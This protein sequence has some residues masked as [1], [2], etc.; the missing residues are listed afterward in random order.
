MKSTLSTCLLSV[1]H[2][3]QYLHCFLQRYVWRLEPK[4][5]HSKPDIVHSCCGH[6]PSPLPSRPSKMILADMLRRP[7]TLWPKSIISHTFAGNF[8]EFMGTHAGTSG[9]SGSKSPSSC[10]HSKS[11][12]VCLP[13]EIRCMILFLS[14][15]HPCMT[16]TACM[17]WTRLM[18]LIF[19]RNN[20]PQME[21]M[22]QVC[23]EMMQ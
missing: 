16:P 1:L 3:I 20:F 12:P 5:G 6:T 10:R 9:L 17:Q 21:Q 14:S 19:L 7:H 18:L 23:V 4:S 15:M 11:L 2:K 8:R 13:L 22:I